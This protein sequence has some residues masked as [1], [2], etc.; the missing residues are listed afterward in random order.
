MNVKLNMSTA[1]H[2]QTDEQTENLIQTLSSMI[3]TYI[4]RNQTNWDTALATLEYEYN[5]ARHASTYLTPFEVD[6]GYVPHTLLTR[7]L[8]F[9]VTVRQH[10][11]W[12]NGVKHPRRLL[13][14]V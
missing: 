12:S 14:I 2:P 3:R 9:A 6:L 7:S 4:Q 5:S 8:E 11:T 10:S 13:E 1:D